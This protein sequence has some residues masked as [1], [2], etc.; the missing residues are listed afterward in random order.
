VA[1]GVDGVLGSGRVT[2]RPPGQGCSPRFL[3]GSS[4][5]DIEPLYPVRGGLKSSFAKN[6]KKTSP[7]TVEHVTVLPMMRLIIAVVAGLA[8]A[9]VAIVIVTSALSSNAN[10]TPSNATLYAYGTR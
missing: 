8:I 10:G 6:E 4:A 9:V 2:L 1:V 3:W 7:V 5:P